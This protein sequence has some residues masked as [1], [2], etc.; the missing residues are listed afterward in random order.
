MASSGNLEIALRAWEKRRTVGPVDRECEEAW[1]AQSSDPQGDA[2]TLARLD[3]LALEG[4]AVRH[5][6]QETRDEVD[7]QRNFG[8]ASITH[9]VVETLTYTWPYVTSGAVIAAGLAHF[10][11]NALGALETWKSLRAG[12]S[13]TLSYKGRSIELREGEPVSKVLERIEALVAERDPPPNA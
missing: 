5:Q 6:T 8:G 9:T 10:L 2:I 7:R 1:P 11:N 3:A 12:R 13:I 4:G